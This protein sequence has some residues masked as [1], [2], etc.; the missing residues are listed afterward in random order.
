MQVFAEDCMGCGNCADICPAKKPALVMRPWHPDRSAG[1]QSAL[2]LQPAGAR[3]SGH[4]ATRSRAASST[5]PCWS[6][7]APA[8]DAV[9]RPT[10]SCSPSLFGERMVIGNATGCSS[11]WGGSAPS[12]P[13]LRQRRRLR[14]HLG[15]LPVRRPGRIHLRHVSGAAAAAP[16]AGRPGHRG[17]DTD[18][19]DD[20]KAAMKGWLENMRDAEGSKRYGDQILKCSS[21]MRTIPCWT[22]R[23][24][25]FLF[26]QAVLLDLRG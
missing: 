17:L 9:R 1:A 15:Q 11:I 6:S 20:L 8:P 18:I 10:P 4:P 2:C 22:D 14:S 24:A 5:S 13:L 26:H 3:R 21:P 7:P 23:R 16:G 12:I 25:G 19:D